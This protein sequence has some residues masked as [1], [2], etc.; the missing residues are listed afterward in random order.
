MTG[1]QHNASEVHRVFRPHHWVTNH[2]EG[3][4]LAWG[5][6]PGVAAVLT[7]PGGTPYHATSLRW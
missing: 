5:V 1:T 3:L 2:F 7:V 6:D 4:P